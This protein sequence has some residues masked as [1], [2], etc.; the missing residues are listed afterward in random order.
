MP[1]IITIEDLSDDRLEDFRSV[2]DRDLAG[3][4]QLFM[5]EGEVPLRTLIAHG[6]FQTTAVLLA[7]KRVDGLADALAE[8][9]PEVPVYV[10]D[11]AT[12]EAVVGFKMHRGVMACGQRPERSDY[13]V[14]L[15]SLPAQAERLILGEA[16]G[17]TDNMGALFRNGAAFA[18]SALCFDQQSCDP[19]YRKSI[20]VSAGQ[21][22]AIPFSRDGDIV[23]L[24]QSVQASGFTVAALTPGAQAQ[25]I[26]SWRDRPERI[27]L[28]VGAEGPGLTERALTAADLQLAIP[29]HRSVDSLNVATAAAVALH[30]LQ[31]SAS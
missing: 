6:R 13:R 30:E 26:K 8:L 4:R 25:P 23:D 19:L 31:T 7:A 3:R 15:D 12:V 24:I 28:M 1:K 16:V 29:M 21:A 20:R 22:L 2:R 9:S 11:Q 10:S 5:V 27:A 17:N 18:V 14:V